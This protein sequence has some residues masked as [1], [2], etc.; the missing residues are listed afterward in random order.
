MI[1]GNYRIGGICIQLHT[2]YEQ[3]HALCRDYASADPPDETIIITQ[4]DIDAERER[5]AS[6]DRNAGRPVR[7]YTDHYLESLAVYRKLAEQLLAYDTLL[8][9][10]SAIAVDGEAYL[11]TA[12]SG[13]GKSTHTALWRALFGERAVM[14]NDDKPLLQI[15]DDRILI[16]GTPWD[17]KH[18]LSSNLACPLRAICL[19]E[20]APDNRIT[21]L[22]KAEAYPALLRQCYRSDDSVKLEHTLALLDA[23][24]DRVGL[25]RLCCNREPAAAQLAYKTMK[26]G[27]V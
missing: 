11:F 8:F 18:H 7:E 1:T 12:K 23:L 15:S 4:P 9:H 6:A 27:E 16:Y 19:L 26:G 13:T 22:R 17:G 24:A 21:G 2:L 20:R 3:V 5:S 25:Y 14:I 10:G